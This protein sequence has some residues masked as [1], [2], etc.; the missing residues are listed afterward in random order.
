MDLAPNQIGQNL[1]TGS[2]AIFSQI[3]ITGSF[4]VTS[5]SIDP[6]RTATSLIFNDAIGHLGLIELQ[7]KGRAFT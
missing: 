3:R 2:G 7:L 4:L 6:S 1:S 5:I